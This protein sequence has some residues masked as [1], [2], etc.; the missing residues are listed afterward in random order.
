MAQ[1]PVGESI[2]QSRDVLRPDGTWVGGTS[3]E[4]MPT[5][6]VARLFP[7]FAADESPGRPATVAWL[8]EINTDG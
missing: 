3:A 2:S 7:D 8:L 1:N 6:P 5:A 4:E